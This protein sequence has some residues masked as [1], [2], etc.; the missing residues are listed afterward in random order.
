MDEE[1]SS[2]LQAI[3]SPALAGFRRRCGVACSRHRADGRCLFLAL[4]FNVAFKAR[5][6]L[7]KPCP[8]SDRVF[9]RIFPN[10]Q[11]EPGADRRQTRGGLSFRLSGLEEL[12]S[13][14]GHDGDGLYN[15]APARSEGHRC[16]GLFY[17]GIGPDLRQF[18]IFPGIF[19]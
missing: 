7:N 6:R 9:F 11:E 10:R 5:Y 2:K 8:G 14:F 18:P 19:R 3:R 15:P 12:F 1:S 17:N 16:N 13:H 4:S